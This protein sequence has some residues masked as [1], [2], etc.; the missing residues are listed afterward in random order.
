MISLRLMTACLLLLATAGPSLAELHVANIFQ[1]H[2]IVQRDVPVKIWGRAGGGEKLT[3]RFAG[4]TIETTADADGAWSATLKPLAASHQ[5]Q[6]LHIDGQTES[7]VIRDVLAGEL[8]H[9]CGQSNM[10]MNVGQMTQELSVV[11]ADIAA[12]NFPS[13]RFCRIHAGPM[14]GPLEDLSS[15]PSW[16]VCTPKTVAGFSGVAFYFARKLQQELDVPVGIIDTSRGG[17]PIEPYIPRAAFTSHPTLEKERELA[18]RQDLEALRR[19]SGGVYA[20]DANWLPGRLFNSR[21]APIMRL[22]VRGAIWYQGESNSGTQEDP[23]DY[24][25]KMRALVNGWRKAMSHE[26]LPFYFVQLPGSGA[27]AGWPYLREQQRL[28]TDVPHTGM[29]VT[30]DIAGGGIHPANKI[31]V[32]QRLARWALAHDYGQQVPFSGPMY[33]R[34]EIDG[35]HIRLHFKHASPRLM[36]ATKPG[37]HAPQQT[38]GG[39][40]THFEI[41][42]TEG[43]W[44]AAEATIEGQKVV[45]TSPKV[46]TPIAVRYAYA[47][48]PESVPLYNQH[49]L[50]ASPFCTKPELLKYDPQLPK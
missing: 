40:L 18:D 45:V 27:G 36:V 6:P 1:D 49:G 38:P 37:L 5:G 46:H 12:A 50:P 2:M 16:T 20:R 17:T 19:L 35:N 39:K 9:A 42:D 8:W 31:D 24:A 10:A 13:L 34:Q 32:G 41:A 44:H 47:V 14:T 7:K 21:L 48:S 29:V 3:V 28:A 25:H 4:Q 11:E 30:L 22:P 43:R 26:D 33:Q 15:P 23:H